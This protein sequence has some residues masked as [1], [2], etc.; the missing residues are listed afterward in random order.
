MGHANSHTPLAFWGVS[1]MEEILKMKA[2]GSIF[3]DSYQS[4]GIILRKLQ[5]MKLNEGSIKLQKVVIPIDFV[6]CQAVFAL[7]S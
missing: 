2:M 3:T 4:L 6:L 1:K 5:N 7:Q